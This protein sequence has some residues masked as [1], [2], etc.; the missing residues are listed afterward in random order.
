MM[1][2]TKDLC[3]VIAR[4]RNN[5]KATNNDVTFVVLQKNMRSMHSS[6]RIEEVVCELEGYR[7]MHYHCVKR[8]GKE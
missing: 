7:W 5:E 1:S 3:G 6:E 8:G 2:G 4:K